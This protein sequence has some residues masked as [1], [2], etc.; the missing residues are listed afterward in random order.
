MSG[1]FVESR[2]ETA[3]RHM[4]RRTACVGN[5]VRLLVLL[6]VVSGAGACDAAG[7][8][9]RQAA[10]LGEEA[11][12][13]QIAGDPFTPLAELTRLP[14]FELEDADVPDDYPV[15]AAS[16]FNSK[17]HLCVFVVPAA[18]EPEVLGDEWH[19]SFVS[20]GPP[21]RHYDRLF[22][23]TPAEQPLAIPPCRMWYVVPHRTVHVDEVRRVVSEERIPGLRMPCATDEFLS[24][25]AEMKTLK[26]LAIGECIFCK[27]KVTDNGLRH[28]RGLRG[29][30]YLDIRGLGITGDG[31]GAL[32]GLTE[33]RGLD[34]SETLVTDDGLSHL[35]HF[36]GL[37]DLRDPRVHGHVSVGD[38]VRDLLLVQDGEHP[39]L[40]RHHAFSFPAKR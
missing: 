27:R 33:L 35:V 8:A 31:L 29:L 9:W 2:G 4:R 21:L 40:V 13:P 10:L 36:A 28:I 38:L 18:Q 12:H 3:C 6:G 5:A 16:S 7:G 17:T 22:G 24:G 14:L 25:L 32:N 39:L 23:V 19:S 26:M 30:V 20:G 1:A 37:R 11:M 15:Y 34:L